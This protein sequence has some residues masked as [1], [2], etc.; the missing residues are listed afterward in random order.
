MPVLITITTISYLFFR[1]G[2]SASFLAP[3]ALR[4]RLE[5]LP[6]DPSRDEALEIAD[7]V[8][9]LARD[10]DQ[11][12]ERATTTYAED[13]LNHASSADSLIALLKRHDEERGEVLRRLVRLRQ[14]ML[15]GLSE[16]EWR[17]VFKG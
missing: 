14:E 7:Q 5:K 8:D 4:K 9:A 17:K 3:S 15:E 6:A 1:G 10:Y 16:K 2:S 12:T 11:A 13:V